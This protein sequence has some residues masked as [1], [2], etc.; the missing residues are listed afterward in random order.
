MTRCTFILGDYEVD[1]DYGVDHLIP[2]YE[3][4]AVRVDGQP[5]DLALH[6]LPDIVQHS[7]KASWNRIGQEQVRHNRNQE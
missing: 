1:F 2:F 7:F 6:Q 3:V 4:V 5:S